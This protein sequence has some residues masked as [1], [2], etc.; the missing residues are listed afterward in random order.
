MGGCN[1]GARAWIIGLDKAGKIQV[2]DRVY[3]VLPHKADRLFLDGQRLHAANDRE[4]RAHATETNLQIRKSYARK[5]KGA[6]LFFF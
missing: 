2:P 1:V 4:R 5:Q 6:P 3:G